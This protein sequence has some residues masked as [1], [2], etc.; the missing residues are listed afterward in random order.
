MLICYRSS[1]AYRA[2]PDEDPSFQIKARTLE[3]VPKAAAIPYILTCDLQTDTDPDPVY[4]LDADPDP[5]SGSQND[6]DPDPQHCT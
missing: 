6:A 5:D 2:D 3:K 4:P 1:P